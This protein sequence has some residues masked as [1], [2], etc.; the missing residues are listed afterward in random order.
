MRPD[1]VEYTNQYPDLQQ[2]GEVQLSELLVSKG[3]Q[4][5]VSE[6][7]QDGAMVHRSSA[8]NPVSTQDV[9]AEA[10]MRRICLSYFKQNGKWYSDHLMDVPTEI[11]TWSDIIKWITT[12]AAKHELPG[13]VPGSL[14]FSPR[15]LITFPNGDIQDPEGVIYGIQHLIL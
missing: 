11:H 12:L 1:R 3:E 15:I 5:H 7:L 13:L 4:G 10:I 6:I 2:L 9:G 14:A 8:Q